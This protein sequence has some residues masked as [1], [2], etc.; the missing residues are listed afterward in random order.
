MAINVGCHE[1]KPGVKKKI[2]T[3]NI[4]NQKL[5]SYINIIHNPNLHEDLAHDTFI[6]WVGRQHAFNISNQR[7]KQLPEAVRQKAF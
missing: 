7:T 5:M 2:L 1:N 6:E 4:L 3:F